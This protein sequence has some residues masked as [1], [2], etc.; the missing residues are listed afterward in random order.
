MELSGRLWRRVW[1]AVLVL[2]VL[3][4][5]LQTV[6]YAFTNYDENFQVVDNPLIRSL[7]PA[8]MARIFSRFSLTNYYP[9]RVLSFAVDYAVWGLDP[10]GYHLTNVLVHAANV[11][12]LWLLAAGLL[13]SRAPDARTG[14]AASGPGWAAACAFCG[15]GLFAVHPVVVEPVAW[16]G[17]REELLMLLFGL[18][19]LHA[20]RK[21]LAAGAA[22]RAWRW[23]ALA[24]L[25]C[26]LSCLSNVVGAIVPAIVLAHD[27]C[28]HG[29]GRGS[30]PASE[31]AHPARPAC[32][33]YLLP[34]GLVT[35]VIKKV[36]DHLARPVGWVAE[37]TDLSIAARLLTI[38]D[39]FWLNV[40]TLLWP[41]HLAVIYPAQ[42]PTGILEPGVIL[43]VVL[44]GA[45]AAWIG[46]SRRRRPLLCFGFVWF[47]LGLAPSA[48]ILPHHI[49]RA[50]RFLYLPLA[51][52]ALA[53]SAG[54][55]VW[56]RRAALRRPVLGVAVLLL[57]G[58]GFLSARRAAVWRDSLTLF[59]DCLQTHPE[60]VK[61]LVNVGDALLRE[62]RLA[63]AMP[64]FSRALALD[65]D[66]ADAHFN[67]A[68]ALLKAGSIELAAFHYSQAVALFPAHVRAHNNLGTVLLRKRELAAAERHFR[69]AVQ[70]DPRNVDYRCNLGAVLADL[71]QLDAALT[72]LREVL[73]LFP[74]STAARFNMGLIHARKGDWQ[75]ARRCYEDVLA[76]DAAHFP[77]A[78]QLGRLLARQGDRAGA[79]AALARAVQLRPD[80]AGAAELLAELRA[81]Q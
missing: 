49:F 43:G 62:G 50:D 33:W 74:G 44:I 23:R 9:V 38:P 8:N 1:P 17:G 37:G 42:V 15:A 18:L 26:V 40:R 34:I 72:E 51:G 24:V 57:A 22:A 13:A 7:A 12:L 31:H 76:R 32:S 81:G 58:L 67:C 3:G 69:H 78:Y 4:V 46:F 5:F 79:M 48:Q 11:W 56:P 27:S 21:A 60:S 53:V 47:V 39:T 28:L 65:P 14:A 45:V 71:G 80:H 6:R 10:S 54:L 73:E 36:A 2:L 59:R 64:A 52:L 25:A 55:G 20:H 16:V 41:R 75:A 66:D 30:D 68:N 29:A 70:V 35:V 61:A 77:A 63:E 19:C